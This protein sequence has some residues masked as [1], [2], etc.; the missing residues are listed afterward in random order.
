M[1]TKITWTPIR[2]ENNWG[3]HRYWRNELGQIAITDYSLRVRGQPETTDDG[4][5]FVDTATPLTQTSQGSLLIPLLTPEGKKYCT[6]ATAEDVQF[7]IKQF[8]MTSQIPPE[9]QPRRAYWAS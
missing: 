2:K 5:L 6:P 8:G 4:L 9:P 7:C 1:T 3:G